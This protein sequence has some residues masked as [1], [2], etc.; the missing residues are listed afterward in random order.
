MPKKSENKKLKISSKR[1]I[2]IFIVLAIAVE[3]IFYSIFQPWYNGDF[4]PFNQMSFYFYTTGVVALSVIFC[5]VS[6]TQTFYIVDRSSITHNKMGHEYR[7]NFNDMVYIDEEWSKKHKM[8]LFYLKDG[9]SKFLAFDKEGIIYDY[10]LKY[11]VHRLT[12]EEFQRA[13][14]NVK[15]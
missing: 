12:K 11:S 7:Y 8:L 5:I 1:I 15:L 10:A 6:I 9:K 2:I 4:N 3:A 14:P 13:Y